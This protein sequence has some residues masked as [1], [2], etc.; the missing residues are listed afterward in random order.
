MKGV[1][2]GS[3]ERF[4]EGGLCKEGRVGRER[5]EPTN[6]RINGLESGGGWLFGGLGRVVVGGGRERRGARAN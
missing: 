3:W 4:C 1:V 5:R 6:T 2:E